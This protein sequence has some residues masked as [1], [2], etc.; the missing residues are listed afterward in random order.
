MLYRFSVK[1]FRSIRNEAVLD[2]QA[3]PSVNEHGES[4]LVDGMHGSFL[5]VAVV[6]GPNGGGK[7]NVLM[8]LTA[9]RSILMGAMI[10]RNLDEGAESVSLIGRVVKP[11][12]LDDT[13][14]S[15]PT[16]FDIY[17][18]A[19][20]IVFRYRLEILQGKVVRELCEYEQE[21]RDRTLFDRN[22]SDF[23]TDDKGLGLESLW[24]GYSEEKAFMAGLFEYKAGNT[25]IAAARKWFGGQLHK[26]FD[27]STVD[28]TIILPIAPD[29]KD[30]LLRRFNEMD[31]GIS[32]FTL[33]GDTEERKR[34]MVSHAGTGGKVYK[35]GVEY[36]SAGTRKI[37]SFFAYLVTAIE[38]G[39]LVV[40]D[41]LD[42][43]LHTLLLRYIVGMFTT[44]G[45]NKR[46]A[47]LIF[48]SHDMATLNKEVFRRD[49]IWFAAKNGRNATDLYSM[50]DF[51]SDKSEG[52]SEKS[53]AQDYLDGMY[54][55]DPYLQAI[56]MMEREGQ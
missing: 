47:Q 28:K 53:Y 34:L 17:F 51:K 15:E 20:C 46:G 22:G 29:K 27:N 30:D 14:R 3:I 56:E 40:L 35:L 48:T 41:E 18:S 5:P 42:A 2:M 11:F 9:L 6:Y 38:E 26:N 55:A 4:L 32:D 37:L 44:P 21:G 49:E 10:V 13:S 7:S 36:E 1:N 12:M 43:K 24:E 25:V 50:A 16:V 52:I 54:G 23:R 8:A 45:F 19:E 39:V 31:L 33:E